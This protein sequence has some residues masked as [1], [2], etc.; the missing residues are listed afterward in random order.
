VSKLINKIKHIHNYSRSYLGRVVF[1]NFSKNLIVIGVTGTKGKT[2]T[3]ELI[4]T[5]L[6]ACGYKTAVISSAHIMI[7]DKKILNTTGNTMIGRGRAQKILAMAV[8]EGCRFA[9]IEVSS[10]G[11]VQHRHRFIE[12]DAAVFMNL[13]PEHIDA[14]GGFEN[15]REAKLDFFRYVAKSPKPVKVFFVNKEDENVAHFISAAGDNKIVFFN[16]TF[17]KAN[18][19]AA[20]AVAEH[21]GCD[22]QIVGVALDNFR[23]V[24]G[25]VEIVVEEPFRVI[26]DYAHTPDSLEQVYKWAI[27]PSKVS[28]KNIKLICVLGSCGGG[29]DKWKRPKMGEVSA[30]YC[31]EIIVTNEDPYDENPAD[32]IDAVASGAESAGKKVIKIIDRQEAIDKAV[33]LAEDGDTVIITGKGSERYI[34]FAKGRKLTW[35]EREAAERAMKDRN[36][37]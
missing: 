27:L 24:P 29:R 20:T 19:A 3:V 6:T 8:R 25:R 32:I 21:F 23:G 17:L 33:S 4:A 1:G 12:W 31:D 10:Q 26:V 5:A 16:G 2:S 30:K 18:Y 15:Y 28:N 35:S 34:H 14:H 7:G 13:H 9:I 36:K 37:I 11:A 22:K